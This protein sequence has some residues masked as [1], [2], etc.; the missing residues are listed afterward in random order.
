MA[1][2]AAPFEIKR[3][4][5]IIQGGLLTGDWVISPT[6]VEGNEFMLMSKGD[7]RLA[8]SMGCDM[9]MVHPWGRSSFLNK[10]G[11]LRD[12]AIDRLIIQSRVADDPAADIDVGDRAVQGSRF[13]AYQDAGVP[14]V[15]AVEF[16][17]FVS[18]TGE[19]TGGMVLQMLSTP[20]KGSFASVEV[21]EANLEFLRLAS[22]N[23]HDNVPSKK[24][25]LEFDWDDLPTLDSKVVKYRRRGAS[26]SLFCKY[27]GRDGK[28]HYHFETPS[29]MP[30]T[31]LQHEIY[32]K[33]A[34]NIDTFYRDNHVPLQYD[35][36]QGPVNCDS[37]E[38]L[39]DGD[40]Y[41]DSDRHDVTSRSASDPNSRGLC[42]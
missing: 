31:E 15:I 21:S 29:K 6:V 10:L 16:P 24:R 4:C 26:I 7:R 39:E 12:Q 27:R 34:A 30:T 9:S 22:E 13:K 42:V 20:K 3:H 18:S 1:A 36:H 28:F 11:E 19:A 8:R 37:P 17:G 23:W 33:V 41:V 38:H 2:Q 25:S 5:I 14:Q 40:D 35:E 32:L